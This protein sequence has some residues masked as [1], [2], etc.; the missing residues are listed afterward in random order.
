MTGVDELNE[1]MSAAIAEYV[2]KRPESAQLHERARRHLP[3]GNTRSVLDIKPFPFKVASADG[4]YLTD[5][6][7]HR[8]LDLLGNYSAGIFGHS[9]AVLHETL[10][11]ALD[12]GWSL[13]AT[14]T[15]EIEL[16]E[17][18]CERFPSLD[19]VRFTNSGTEAN[20]MALATAKHVTGHGEILMFAGGYHGGV[21]YFGDTGRPLAVPHDYVH[22]PYNQ[23]AGLAALFEQHALAA[24]LVE[25]MLGSGGCYPADQAF[26]QTLRDLCTQHGTI[27][28]FDEVMTS[29]L[30]IGGAQ[31]AL[32]VTPDMTTLGKYLGGSMSF[33]A[34]GGRRDIMEVFDPESSRGVTHGGTFN[35][36]VLTMRAGV[37]AL[38]HLVTSDSLR[39]LNDRGDRLRQRLVEPLAVHGLHATGWGSLIG[40]HADDDPRRLDLFFY[41]MLNAGFYF[42][43]RGYLA[44]SM[45]VTDDDLDRFVKSVANT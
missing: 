19:M 8:Y 13:G 2:I 31:L 27:L 22:A 17:L 23:V 32:G 42:A 41:R 45:A 12:N 3:G 21:L 24:V 14:H 7:G 34:F 28:I 26:L 35:N 29:R 38:R 11:A 9:P 20:L 30:S 43:P 18:L 1:L 16:A 39:E 37:T 4:A 33:G 36:N 40:I 44:L 10:L 6:D 25:P 15:A 5:V